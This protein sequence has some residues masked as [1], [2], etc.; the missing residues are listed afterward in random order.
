[1]ATVTG[2]ALSVVPCQQLSP[3]TF[4]GSVRVDW[5]SCAALASSA[6]YFWLTMT[7]WALPSAL[8]MTYTV[9]LL[10]WE[11][12]VSCT[13]FF[14]A[15]VSAAGALWVFPEA[16]KADTPARLPTSATASTMAMILF[17]FISLPPVFS[18]PKDGAC[19]GWSC[20]SRRRTGSAVRAA[21]AVPAAH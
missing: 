12:V 5:A 14:W 15:A 13:S 7:F 2:S 18:F 9:S 11:A 4:W 1:M 17:F 16:A 3:F 20:R 19:R 6:S 10:V 8:A 21:P